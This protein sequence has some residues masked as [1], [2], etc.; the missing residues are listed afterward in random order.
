[1]NKRLYLTGIILSITL[2][3]FAQDIDSSLMKIAQFP[4]R[5]FSKL[6]NETDHLEQSLTKQT[7]RYLERL[8]K[9]ERKIQEKLSKKDSVAAKNLFAGTQEKY[10][11]LEEQIKKVDGEGKALSGEYLPYIDSIK[12]SLSFIQKYQNVLTTSPELQSKISGS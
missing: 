12:G 6:K 9:K 4:N 5:L 8:A 2:F 1:M 3:A 10:L 11:A 7:E